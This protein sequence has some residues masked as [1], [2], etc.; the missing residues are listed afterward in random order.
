MR[1]PDVTKLLLALVTFK[2]LLRKV[3]IVYIA[4]IASIILVIILIG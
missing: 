2:A 4:M 1:Y 3:D